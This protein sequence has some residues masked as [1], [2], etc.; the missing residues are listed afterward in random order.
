MDRRVNSTNNAEKRR[1]ESNANRNTARRKSI[2]LF[3]FFFVLSVRIKKQTVTN[4]HGQQPP[5]T[6]DRTS[7]NGTANAARVRTKN[8][9]PKCRESKDHGSPNRSCAS[10]AFC[11]GTLQSNFSK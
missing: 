9:G 10:K 6:A 8:P 3:F 2:Y 7:N 1:A 4:E 5:A 11:I